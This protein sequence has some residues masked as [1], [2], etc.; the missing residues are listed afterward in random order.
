[1]TTSPKQ[2]S[3]VE[4]AAWL[5]STKPSRPAS[6]C[7]VTAPLLIALRRQ[8]NSC[9]VAI[10]A[11]RAIADTFAPGFSVALISR[12]FAC[13]DQRLRA[14]C[15]LA[16]SRFG[17]ASR[18]WKLLSSDIGADPDIDT[19]SSSA[20]SVSSSL[21]HHLMPRQMG[22]VQRFRLLRGSA[23]TARLFPEDKAHQ[24]R[25]AHAQSA[26]CSDDPAGG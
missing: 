8:P 19:A 16:S 14:R 23:Q 13:A 6:R 2:I 18:I 22:C 1:M 9:E 3:T 5:T 21:A 10:P 11:Y 4:D 25:L 26:A 24:S 17:T 7:G 15:G 12:A 20:P